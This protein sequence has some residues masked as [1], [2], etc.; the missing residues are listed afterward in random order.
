MYDGDA[1]EE[2]EAVVI[3]GTGWLGQAFA[4]RV[5]EE[6]GD[7][8]GRGEGVAVLV[9]LPVLSTDAEDESTGGSVAGGSGE[10]QQVVMHDEL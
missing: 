2:G 7:V 5:G 1:Q 9:G 8:V 3:V 4:L 6:Y 10:E